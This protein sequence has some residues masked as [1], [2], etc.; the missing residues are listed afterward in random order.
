MSLNPIKPKNKRIQR[1][2]ARRQVVDA[3]AEQAIQQIDNDLDLLGASPT[4]A[5]VV[6]IVGRLLRRQRKLINYVRR[7]D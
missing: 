3:K 7:L 5:Q 6:A 4:N 2:I 1:E